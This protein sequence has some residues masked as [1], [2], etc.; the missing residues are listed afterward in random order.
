MEWDAADLRRIYH[1]CVDGYD[2]VFT[3]L[4]RHWWLNVEVRNYCRNEC[5][6]GNHASVDI[7][8]CKSHHCCTGSERN[9]HLEFERS[10]QLHRF[11]WLGGFGSDKRFGNYRRDQQDH[12]I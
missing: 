8:H 6:G 3:Q 4:F 12:G 10:N 11:R 1:A 9:S 7:S 5:F 2:D